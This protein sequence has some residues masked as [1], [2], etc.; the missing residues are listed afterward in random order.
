MNGANELRTHIRDERNSGLLWSALVSNR[1]W[2]Y[3]AADIF[4]KYQKRS[5]AHIVEKKI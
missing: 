4:S 5:E 2:S 3:A 1:R